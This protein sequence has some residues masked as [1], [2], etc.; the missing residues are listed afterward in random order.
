MAFYE[1]VAVR[2]NKAGADVTGYDSFSEA[3]DG[4]RVAAEIAKQSGIYVQIFVRQ[5]FKTHYGYERYRI[6]HKLHEKAN[7]VR[8]RPI[9]KSRTYP[10]SSPALLDHSRRSSPG[11]PRWAR[12]LPRLAR[13]L[14]RVQTAGFGDARAPGIPLLPL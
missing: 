5:Y 7:R 2:P 14:E 10:E 8:R 3:K 9:P 6:L 13:W 12:S 11:V 4:L 1:V